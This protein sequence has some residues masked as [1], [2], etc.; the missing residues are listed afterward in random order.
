MSV[1]LASRLEDAESLGRM[2][3]V[4]RHEDARA[5]SGIWPSDAFVPAARRLR[6]ARVVM[7]SPGFWEFLGALNPLQQ[8]REYLNDRHERS[9]D[10]GYRNDNERERLAVELKLKEAEL[11]RAEL[12]VGLEEFRIASEILGAEEA[13][14]LAADRLTRLGYLL[15]STQPLMLLG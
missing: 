14:N 5:N 12:A 2:A 11:R 4:R 3:S 15:D 13:R 6:V 8:L 10:R 9:K 7:R 1:Q